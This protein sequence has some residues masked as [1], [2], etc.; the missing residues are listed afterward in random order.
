MLITTLQS[1]D[2][3]LKVCD[4]IF[5]CSPNT[6]FT[7]TPTEQSIDLILKVRDM[8][9]ECSPNTGLQLHLQ[10]KALI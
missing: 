2:L 7:I 5:E 3:I 4:M 9:F 10:S 6:G 1:I 8:I